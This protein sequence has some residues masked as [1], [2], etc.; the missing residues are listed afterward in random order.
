VAPTE[1]PDKKTVGPSRRKIIPS[2]KKSCNFPLSGCTFF[3]VSFPL[4]PKLDPE[5]TSTKK[6]KT[7]KIQHEEKHPP[8]V[9]KNLPAASIFQLYQGVEQPSSAF[10][11]LYLPVAS[12]Q[13][14]TE[15]LHLPEKD[16]PFFHDIYIRILLTSTQ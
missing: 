6:K 1:R 9:L 4:L 2:P 8:A 15:S 12:N 11:K 7:L 5:I 13:V 10:S 16:Q 14:P 3:F